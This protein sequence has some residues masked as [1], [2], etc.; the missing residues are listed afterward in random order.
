M[1]EFSMR[2]IS[3]PPRFG[4]GQ[5]SGDLIWEEPMGWA[6]TR[7]EILQRSVLALMGLPSMHPVI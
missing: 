7:S 4:D 6:P 3:R 1:S 5:D 2:P